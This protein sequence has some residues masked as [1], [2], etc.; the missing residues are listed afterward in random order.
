[1]AWI[2][3]TS[4]AFEQMLL[5]QEKSAIDAIGLPEG[6]TAAEILADNLTRVTNRVRGYCPS[7][8]PL[9]A[10]GTIP[11]ELEDSALILVLQRYFSRPGL[12]RLWSDM[13]NQEYLRAIELLER[14]SNRKFR[15]VPPETEA[16]ADEQPAAGAAELV[17]PDE[18]TPRWSDMTMDGL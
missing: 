18:S 8:V 9:G 6:Q 14:W 2:T 15:V 17:E 7:D 4:A 12:K 3:L 10:A 1:M 13:R 11:D 5:A 16:A